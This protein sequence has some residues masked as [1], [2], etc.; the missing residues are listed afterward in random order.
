MRICLQ[1]SITLHVIAIYCAPCSIPYLTPC[2]IPCFTS[3][4]AL[5]FTFF[6]CALSGYTALYLMPCSVPC[7]A[8]QFSAFPLFIVL[9]CIP[10]RALLNLI[11]HVYF[12]F[13]FPA[14]GCIVFTSARKI[15]FKLWDFACRALKKNKKLANNTSNKP[16]QPQRA[17]IRACVIEI[18]KFNIQ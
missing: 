2:T 17:I 6:I 3:Y 14:F 1:P 8:M 15:D 13:F 18:E 11:L 12:A 5:C 10:F 4:F 7:L 16:A 9:L